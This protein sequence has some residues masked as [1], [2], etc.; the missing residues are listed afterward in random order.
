MIFSSLRSFIVGYFHFA[1]LKPF[2]LKKAI[3][4]YE[5]EEN[6]S[7]RYIPLPIS[8]EFLQHSSNCVPEFIIHLMNVIDLTYVSGYIIVLAPM[9]KCEHDQDLNKLASEDQNI[10]LTST[11]SILQRDQQ[12]SEYNCSRKAVLVEN[13][14][15]TIMKEHKPIYFITLRLGLPI[16]NMELNHAVCAQ[17]SN[18]NLLSTNNRNHL[19]ATNHLLVEEFTKFIFNDCSGLLP[20]QNQCSYST[21]VT[22]S[23]GN[24]PDTWPL[25]TKN[26]MCANGILSFF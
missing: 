1:L 16:F 2:S 23:G 18:Q 15:L 8:K 5:F 6:L 26:M 14:L 3:E 11:D 12:K 9:N 24:F 19:E 17:I 10:L 20:N 4:S 21:L 13:E 22:S 25:P 7:Q